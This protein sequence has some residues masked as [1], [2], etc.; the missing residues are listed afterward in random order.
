VA[1][2]LP[3]DASGGVSGS[4]AL[5]TTAR[6][7]AIAAAATLAV[8]TSLPYLYGYLS[9]PDDKWFSGVIYNVHDTAQYWSWMRESATHL[10][11]ENKLTS[12]SNPP[13]FLNLHWWIPGRVAALSGL[14]LRLVYQVFRLLAVAVYAGVAAWLCSVVFAD[15]RRRRFAFCLTTVTSGLGWIWVVEKYVSRRADALWPHDIYMLPGN[16]FWVLLASPHLA[17]AL[18]LTLLVLGLAWQSHHQ[19]RLVLSVLAGAVALFLGFGHVYDLVTVWAI[20]GTFALLLT[21]RDGLRWRTVTQFLA[22]VLVSAPAPLY[23]GWL[24]SSAHPLWHRA[25]AQ[26]DN[27]GVFTPSVPHLFVLCGIPLVLALTE[28]VITARTMLSASARLPDRQLFLNSWLIANLVVVYLPLHFQ[29]ML[30]TGLQFVLAALA[31]DFVFERLMP[32]W[33]GRP[34]HRW[35]P[36][37]VLLSVL[38]NNI[39]LFAW[40]FVDLH[41]YTY[42]FYLHRDDISAMRWLESH[43][44]GDDVVLSAFVTG[45]YIPGLTG[46]HAFLGSAVMT[47]DFNAKRVLVERFFDAQTAPE[48]RRALLREF[49]VDYVFYGTLE[50]EL[51]AFDPSAAEYLR[52]AFQSPTATVY[53]AVP[54]R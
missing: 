28:F 32:W 44:H 46:A 24:S 43:V 31:T 16:S 34:A 9:G 21:L 15:P 17:L 47:L 7:D 26:F 37:I 10:F 25:L 29:V 52:P 40:R 14:S 5:T 48:G 19:Q 53:R 54:A 49:G 36:A 2:S 11:I 33:A 23:F 6:G 22:V 27:L 8:V 45:Q 12:E 20:V 51:G 4:T 13:I 38:P 18:A 35:L 30:F 3:R 50:R 1:D 42:P 41:R 39:Y